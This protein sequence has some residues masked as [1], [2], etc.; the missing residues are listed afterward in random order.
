MGLRGPLAIVNPARGNPGRRPPKGPKVSP[1]VVEEADRVYRRLVDLG[2]KYLAHDEA[3]WDSEEKP[4]KASPALTAALRCFEKAFLIKF[5][6]AGS[7]QP[8]EV[9]RLQSHLSKRPK[10]PRSA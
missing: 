4:A 3:R 5:R 8:Q 1:E 10:A 7:V 6:I 9:D 2:D